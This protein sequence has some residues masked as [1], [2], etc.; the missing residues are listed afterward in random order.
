MTI[1]GFDFG[2]GHDSHITRL[3]SSTIGQLFD[4]A[5]AY[6]L[7]LMVCQVDLL[8]NVTKRSTVSFHGHCFEPARSA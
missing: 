3:C 1:E 6:Q 2:L 4:A 7:D 8:S 5:K